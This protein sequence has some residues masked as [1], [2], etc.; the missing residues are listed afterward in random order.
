MLGEDT[1]LDKFLHAHTPSEEWHLAHPGEPSPRYGTVPVTEVDGKS[2]MLFDWKDTLEESLVGLVKETRFTSIPDHVNHDMELNLVYEGSCEYLVGGS[3]HLLHQG[4]VI[5]FDTGVIRS[6][7]SYK[8]ENDIVL[9]MVFRKEFFDS[10]FLSQLPGSG[11]LTSLL[12]EA[13]SDRRCHDRYL[14]I[15]TA[16]TGRSSRLMAFLFEEYYFSDLY[17]PELI[18]SYVTSLFLELI[19]GLYRQSAASEGIA[20]RQRKM[21]DILGFIERHYAECTLEML[22]CKFGYSQNYLG[23]LIKSQTGK[24]FSEI[25]AAQQMAEAAYLLSNTDRAV[26]QIAR[27]V[28]ISNMTYFYRKFKNCFGMTPHEYRVCIGNGPLKADAQKS[29]EK[30]YIIDKSG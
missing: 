29:S 15:P 7:P 3:R 18:R 28:G 12:F 14:E 2:C 13:I 23:N 6:S 22:S 8:G 1:R 20:W 25:K 24:T 16:Y 26:T 27:K 17:S 5:I 4:D 21:S 30:S 19:R 11:L 9:S 10:V